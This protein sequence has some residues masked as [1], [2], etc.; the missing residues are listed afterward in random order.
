M[1]LK[2]LAIIMDGNG[3]WA[4]KRGLSRSM[5]HRE[6]VKTIGKVVDACLLRNI[7]V[8]SLYVFSTENKKRPKEEVDGLFSLAKSYFG[9]IREFN[10]KGVKVVV[11]GNREDLP[12]EIN[13]RIDEA[14]EKTKNNDKLTLNLCFNYGGRD[15]IVRA[16][17]KFAQ[18][19][20]K[21]LTEESFAKF[22]DADLPPVDFIIR[23]GGEMRLSNFLLYQSAYAEFYFTDVLWPDFKEEEL[24]SALE[25]FGRRKRN[26]GAVK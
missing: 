19:G 26:F 1:E 20:E 16:A 18:S 8:L 21:T 23:T 11:S 5:G 12:E 6:G 15:E 2:H 13:A 24:S 7:P 14:L 17:V 4:L 25:E 10:K 9:K 3:R 22:L